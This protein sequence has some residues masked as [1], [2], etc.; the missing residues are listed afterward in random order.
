MEKEVLEYLENKNYT[1]LKKLF[2][3]LNA[4]DVAALLEEMFGD[5][6]EERELIIL[7]RLLPKDLA[8]DC[9]AFLDSDTQIHLIS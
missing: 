6:I 9:F 5:K 4:A 7:F 1:A 3:D 8:A 2:V